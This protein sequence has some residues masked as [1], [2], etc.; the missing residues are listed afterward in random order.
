MK[1]KTKYSIGLTITIA[2]LMLSF[3][4]FAQ[5]KLKKDFEELERQEMLSNA[6]RLLNT[7]AGE[8]DAIHG[9]IVDYS[10]WDAAYNFTLKPSQAFI[11]ENYGTSTLPG[12]S[13]NL[14]M[15]FD[16]HG[17][18]LYSNQNDSNENG[19]RRT[20]PELSQIIQ[21][22]FIK[23][24]LAF[25]AK[26]PDSNLHKSDLIEYKGRI[27]IVS[28]HFFAQASAE[29][30]KAGE[31]VFG[32]YLDQAILDA[33]RDKT[34]NHT[35]FLTGA[36]LQALGQ[37]LST[38]SDSVRLKQSGEDHYTGT[39]VLRDSKNKPIAAYVA[40]FPRK[41]MAIGHGTIST[42]L[43]S[44]ALIGFAMII[45]VMIMSNR[46]V[47]QR[48][49]KLGR[50][51]EQ[52]GEDPKIEI[53]QSGDELTFL[54]S[55]LNRLF[56]DIRTKNAEIETHNRDRGVMLDNL[57]QG[58]F[59]ITRDGKIHPEYAAQT[60]A[61]FGANTL[62]GQIA[63]EILLVHAQMDSAQ[64]SQVHEAIICCLHGDDFQFDLNSDMLPTEI[65]LLI[66]QQERWLELSWIPVFDDK[67]NVE[68]LL[69]TVRDSTEIR[70][71]Q[72]EMRRQREELLRLEKLLQVNPKDLDHFVRQ[73][74]K[75]ME[76]VS[77]KLSIEQADTNVLNEVFREL[78]TLKGN[79]RILGF[80]D[81]ASVV[82]D[83]EDPVQEMRRTEWSSKLRDLAMI[84]IGRVKRSLDELKHTYMD[85]FKNLLGNS[86]D[87]KILLPKEKIEEILTSMTEHPIHDQAFL[88]N[89]VDSIRT[90]VTHEGIAMD[91]F[92]AVPTSD[93]LGDD[94]KLW[95]YLKSLAQS[96]FV[97]LTELAQK[98]LG[99]LA[100]TAAELGKPLPDFVS[101][102]Q[103][104]MIRQSL[105]GPLSDAMGHLFRN[106]LDH[107][108]EQSSI[109]TLSGK[110][111]RGA[112]KVELLFE[113]KELG[114][115]IPRLVF[116]D[117][118]QGIHLDTLRRKVSE[119][120]IPT[121]NQSPLWLVEQIFL[122][123]LST[124]ETITE[125]SGRGVGMDAVRHIMEEV[126][127]EISVECSEIRDDGTVGV[128]F[129][130]ALPRLS[131]LVFEK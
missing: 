50:Q 93:E 86:P 115:E 10:V 65:Q 38:P 97:P 42:V 94:D 101:P 111:A 67:G 54:Q 69:V 66:D 45:A 53:D 57:S 81:L 61:L 88:S 2:A 121:E 39:L 18:L 123:G 63:H 102:T 83:S 107:G 78:H 15:H 116:Q 124:K 79:A 71:L 30:P 12:L 5:F 127:G 32:R 96:S 60:P 112:I 99:G 35:E 91:D 31:L 110:D 9:N 8:F 80:S 68:L 73:S 40:Q 89:W 25:Q 43:I 126:E 92:T 120:G 58:L 98:Q 17:Q 46:I 6:E 44:I 11:D 119:M 74:H 77:G 27:M 90:M 55:T 118:G 76:V 33:I 125:L 85:K 128:R 23:P 131:T 130:L 4:A 106:S 56:G 22:L 108:I 29:G 117:D 20:D 21:D 104:I 62:V 26:N 70:L 103:E 95:D 19:S 129:I 64:K 114:S 84:R 75:R 51:L 87:P 113:E 72:A 28:R 100:D 24:E 82:H 13:A 34:K 109:R 41:V 37:D 14:L 36:K 16:S 122:P 1:I 3:T 47:L 105:A 7:Y 49:I 52:G 59:M 48:L